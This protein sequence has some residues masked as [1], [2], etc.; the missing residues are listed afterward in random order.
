[1]ARSITLALVAAVFPACK[2]PG[3]SAAEPLAT[4][5]SAD[6]HETIG[7]LVYVSWQQQVSSTAYVEYRFEAEDWLRTPERELE[8]GQQEQ[9]LLGIPFGMDLEYRVVLDDQ[10]GAWTSATEGFQTGGVPPDLP[11]VASVEGDWDHWDAESPY[12]VASINKDGLGFW[13]TFI[14]DRK[15]RYLW[16]MES[17][18]GTVTLQPRISQDGLDLLVDHNTYWGLYDE[19]VGSQV[20]RLK[21]DG[22]VTATYDTPGLQHAYTD[23]EDGSI[24]WGAN[25][26]M[27]TLEILDPSGEQRTL[28]RCED[29]H[30]SLKEKGNCSANN[31]FWSQER[32]SF[33][34]SFFTTEA[35]V[36]VDLESGEALRWFGHLDGSW[37]FSPQDSAFWWQHGA[38]FTEEGTLLLSSQKAHG[39]EETV[40]RE[41]ELDSENELL[42]EIWSF[43]IGEDVYAPTGGV[44]LRLAN[45]NTHHNFG[46]NA[47]LREITPDGQVVWDVLWEGT[48]RL[49]DTRPIENLYDFVP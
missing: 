4:G 1:M 31:L 43:G 8:P 2:D 22:T 5:I 20:L 38:R 15:A 29:L 33:L 24:A 44:A 42:R 21:I 30:A 47:R 10:G 16:A 34:Y 35:V 19:G 23:M 7:S 14:I 12:F 13:W 32:G 49:G 25:A 27:E 11:R 39:A 17:P 45:G 48:P 37:E 3:D 26:P 9:L 18:E 28:W 6:L 40:A 46:S 41:Y 36:E